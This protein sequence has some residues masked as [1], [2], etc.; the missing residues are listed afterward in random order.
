MASQPA[1]IRDTA[2]GMAFRSLDQLLTLRLFLLALRR[3]WLAWRYG[4][5]MPATSSISLSGRIV[6]GERGSLTIG[7]D[8]L[9]AFK[10]LLITR[11]TRTGRTRPIR[12]GNRCFVG[13]GA[14]VLPGVTIGDESIVASGAVVDG[15]VAPRTIVAGN[16]ARQIR[17]NIEV[18]KR[19]RLKGTEDNWPDEWRR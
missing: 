18:G 7:E 17:E 6:L 13:G 12:I 19:G 2:N 10:T 15:D 1:S 4:V 8:S 16:P 3:R 5:R 11:E 14:I 9:V